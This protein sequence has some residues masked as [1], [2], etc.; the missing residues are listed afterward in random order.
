LAPSELCLFSSGWQRF[1]TKSDLGKQISNRT[2]IGEGFLTVA[3]RLSQASISKRMS[4]A[5][6][7]KTTRTEDL[8]YCLLGIF[9]INM[10]LLYGEGENA[11]VR[12]QEEIMK[13]ADDQTLFAWDFTDLRI[14]SS[15]KSSFICP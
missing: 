10:P 14:P 5:S 2:G 13:N 1:G 4:W 15:D 12:L 11:Y 9:E 3:D 7:R 8:A 6:K